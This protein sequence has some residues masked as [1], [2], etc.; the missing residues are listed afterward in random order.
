M[1]GLSLIASISYAL[2]AL[3][4]ATTNNLSSSLASPERHLE[5]ARS[6][7]YQK[8][9]KVEQIEHTPKSTWLALFKSVA[10]LDVAISKLAP[11]G[12][13]EKSRK[14]LKSQF[15][16]TFVHYGLVDGEGKL[17]EVSK[18]DFDG[19]EQHR[20]EVKEETAK[21]IQ[22]KGVLFKTYPELSDYD[23]KHAV[24]YK[25]E[26]LKAT[27]EKLNGTSGLSDDVKRAL[28]EVIS[29]CQ[30]VVQGEV[31]HDWQVHKDLGLST[32]LVKKTERPVE[33]TRPLVNVKPMLDKTILET[34][35]GEAT[36]K[37]LEAK[38][39]LFSLQTTRGHPPESSIHI[40]ALSGLH[41]AKI[42]LQ[43][44]LKTSPASKDEMIA[45][46]H[47]TK[48][49]KLYE[50]F[51]GIPEH[52]TTNVS[53]ATPKM[54]TYTPTIKDL[55]REEQL[56]QAVVGFEKDLSTLRLK[57]HQL[58]VKHGPL[59][60]QY[61]SHLKDCIVKELHDATVTAPLE[62][63][64]DVSQVMELVKILPAAHATTPV[65]PS[66][67]RTQHAGQLTNPD[68]LGAK[69]EEILS[70]NS[71]RLNGAID[72]FSVIP[73]SLIA[74]EKGLEI[75]IKNAYRKI[76]E[77]QTKSDELIEAAG[78]CAIG[79]R[80]DASNAQAML[81]LRDLTE[82]GVA[83]PQKDKSEGAITSQAI[84]FQIAASLNALNK[85]RKKA[86]IRRKPLHA[87]PAETLV[88]LRELE[89]EWNKQHEELKMAKDELYKFWF[90][91]ATKKEPQ[92]PEE[93][94]LVI[95][96][97]I[98]QLNAYILLHPNAAAL[99]LAQKATSHLTSMIQS[100]QKCPTIE[101]PLHSQAP[102]NT[103][104]STVATLAKTE[105][106]K[107]D[108]ANLTAVIL[109]DSRNN[110]LIDLIKK[111]EGMLEKLNVALK[112]LA[113]AELEHTFRGEVAPS[114][115]HQS[116][117]ELEHIKQEASTAI[118]PA[119]KI[120]PEHLKD[121]SA[122]EAERQLI[123]KKK[124]LADVQPPPGDLFEKM[125]KQIIKV[126]HDLKQVNQSEISLKAK[127]EERQAIENLTGALIDLPNKAHSPPQ[128]V[129][130]VEGCL[131]KDTEIRNEF[132]LHYI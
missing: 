15:M 132:D 76:S 28:S 62:I 14:E 2:L 22:L 117:Q 8:V 59:G 35:M 78:G 121:L 53:S 99:E 32:E 9:L 73:E 6:S 90:Q 38:R 61:D 125:E 118:I 60:Q 31:H 82:L 130:K 3:A 129:P 94:V 13:G 98:R 124:E 83:H 41:N 26:L 23:K 24:I 114:K 72:Q 71:L 11:I 39:E 58:E 88:K 48:A 109:K 10:E 69:I 17:P 63:R 113:L 108:I 105:A 126:T 4:A 131:R 25:L 56:K 75:R 16:S 97:V 96:S 18:T 27:L 120:S 111:S 5:E 123:L 102:S 20:K 104:A 101:E 116:I 107:H 92:T 112:H 43:I 42:K 110:G 37:M 81:A 93:A 55:A 115:L 70:P 77:I 79:H 89:Q 122:P 51:S 86:I 12:G 95:K 127:A 103:S 50:Q 21:L 36:E 128:S 66:N 45:L 65:S 91:A 34:R 54:I 106:I 80:F 68:L 100:L 64:G 29:A 19:L 46:D 52:A 47:L 119:S 67:V 74:T 85:F 1:R 57:I 84:G 44:K 33:P 7:L 87:L 40:I 49:I 30:R